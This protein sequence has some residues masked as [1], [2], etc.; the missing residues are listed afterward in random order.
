[1]EVDG[2]CTDGTSSADLRIEPTFPRRLE[3]RAPR[4]ASADSA[5]RLALTRAECST[6]KQQQACSLSRINTPGFDEREQR[7]SQQTRGTF[8]RTS[9]S[10]HD[11]PVFRDRTLPLNIHPDS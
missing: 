10:S 5:L 7:K 3:L 8:A 2:S 4:E 1:M 6:P 11:S 9:L